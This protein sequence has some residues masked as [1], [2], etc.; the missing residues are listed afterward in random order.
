MKKAL[1]II[2][3]CILFAACGIKDDPEFKAHNVFNNN[4]II[5]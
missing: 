4:I 3:A 1:I 5:I 2:T